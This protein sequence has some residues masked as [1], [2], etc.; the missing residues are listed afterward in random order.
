M[1]KKIFRKS[2]ILCS[3]LLLTTALIACSKSNIEDE[4]VVEPPKPKDPPKEDMDKIVVLYYASWT[5]VNAFPNSNLITHINYAF[6]H[7]KASYDGIRIDQDAKLKALV[8]QK[9]QDSKLKILLAIGGWASGGFSEMARDVTKRKSFAND[10]IR[11]INEYKIDGIDLDWEYPTTGVAG[12]GFHA[13]DTK[14]F[15]LL[16]KDIREAIGKDYLLTMASASNGNYV[17]FRNIINEMD[18]INIMGYDYATPPYH[19]AALHGG[20]PISASLTS[21][22]AIELHIGKGVPTNKLVLGM[23]FYGRSNIAGSIAYKNIKGHT[24][25]STYTEKWD[26]NAKVPYYADSEGK[27]VF[28]FDNVNSIKAKCEFALSKKLKGVMCWEFNQDNGE[29]MN[30]ISDIMLKK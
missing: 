7:V 23:P 8:A 28:A 1:K 9:S 11:V 30:A 19:H 2:L 15:T 13:D 5:P 16:V 21:E 4:V 3:Y 26:S 29:L 18:F 12:I 24:A 27:L 17:D 14:N 6:G 22:R 10:C 25:L 20:S